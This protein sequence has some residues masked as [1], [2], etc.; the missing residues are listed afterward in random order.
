MKS[1]LLVCNYFAPENSIGSV[2]PT[3][4]AKFL[5]AEGYDVTVIAEKKDYDVT[6]PLL[7]RDAEGLNINYIKPPW[8][9]APM[10]KFYK[11]MQS[12]SNSKISTID[13]KTGNRAEQERSIFHVFLRFF[14][15][16]SNIGYPI[17]NYKHRILAKKAMRKFKNQKYDVIFTS[18]PEQLALHFG[19]AYKKKHPE[20]Q[21]IMDLR[22]PLSGSSVFPSAKAS[23]INS[24]D[25]KIEQLVYE[26]SDKIISVTKCM[27]EMIPAQYAAKKMFLHN[28]YDIDDKQSGTKQARFTFY[29]TGSTYGGKMDYS[30]VFRIIRELSL[31]GLAEL[32]KIKFVYTGY[33][34]DFSIIKGHAV[35]Y[36]LEGLIS[37]RGRVSR[38]ESMALQ[39]SSH[40]LLVANFDYEDRPVGVRPGK[41]YEYMLAEKPIISISNGSI[42]NCELTQVINECNLGFAFE[43]SQQ[44][45]HYPML[46]DYILDQYNAF[47]ET[48]SVAYSPNREEVEKYDYRNMVKK[49]VEVIES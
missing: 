32:D 43:Y 10:H 13:Q 47:V 44:E 28:G 38:L 37:F 18:F 22:D 34:S 12:K 29:L 45:K 31:E 5:K 35:Q 7:V 4:M 8:Y 39:E 19:L 16:I 46:K 3:K 48:G 1:I 27:N 41:M 36:E 42:V 23:Y 2:R 24:Y 9:F 6:D 26:N 15:L 11:K 14:G 21:W 20:T 25:K 17:L 49:V 40:L 33:E 30:V